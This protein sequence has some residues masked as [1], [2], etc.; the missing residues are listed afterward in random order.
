MGLLK[1][2]ICQYMYFSCGWG[3]EGGFFG[4]ITGWV[5]VKCMMSQ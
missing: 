1:C 5:Q 3:G 4:G 2:I